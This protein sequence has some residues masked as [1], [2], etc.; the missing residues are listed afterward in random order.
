[1]KHLQLFEAFLASQKLN[2]SEDPHG[3]M[4]GVIVS[5]KGTKLKY[6][7]F[8]SAMDYSGTICSEKDLPSLENF[9]LDGK[10]ASTKDGVKHPTEMWDVYGEYSRDKDAW[11]KKFAPVTKALGCKFSDLV[12][13]E[14]LHNE[15]GTYTEEEYEQAFDK[16]QEI[17]FTKK[18]FDLK[19][20]EE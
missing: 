5:I 13:L 6:A 12:F 9:F 3:D 4:D 7:Y 8:D 19:S 20:I 10:V 15:D 1:M 17:E 14:I 18:A 2:E 16:D 11:E